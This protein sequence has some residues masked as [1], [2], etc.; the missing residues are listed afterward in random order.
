MGIII[1]VLLLIV[2]IIGLRYSIILLIA[3]LT[4]ILTFWAKK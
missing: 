3:G 1:G 2:G 4:A